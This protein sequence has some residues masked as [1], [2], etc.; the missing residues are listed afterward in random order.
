MVKEE[1]VS[2]TGL[3]EITD[4]SG[5]WVVSS[6]EETPS[7][8]QRKKPKVKNE[9]VNQEVV[10]NRVEPFDLLPKP[11]F[12]IKP[13]SSS[14]KSEVLGRHVLPVKEEVENVES[15]VDVLPKPMVLNIC[16]HRDGERTWRTG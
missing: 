11:S 14:N 9:V 7:L 13:K 8:S 5:E 6:V 16:Y 1:M 12:I 4:E 15:K 10:L 2:L 3:V